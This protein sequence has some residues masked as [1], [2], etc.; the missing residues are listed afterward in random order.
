MKITYNNQTKTIHAKSKIHNIYLPLRPQY[1][2]QNTLNKEMFCKIRNNSIK[3]NSVHMCPFL[4]QQFIFYTWNF[5]IFYLPVSL[6]FFLFFTKYNFCINISP[7]KVIIWAMEPVYQ[8]KDLYMA[9][10]CTFIT[11]IL[12]FVLNFMLSTTYACRNITGR[13]F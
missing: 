11:F 2:K 12:H 9:F 10:K 1:F 3:Y 5:M 7:C 6:T 13:L 8:N 4:L